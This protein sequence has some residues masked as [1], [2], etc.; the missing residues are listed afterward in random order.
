MK[1]KKNLRK[2]KRP[3]IPLRRKIAV[4]YS[5]IVISIK[6]LLFLVIYLFFFT[7]HLSFIKDE[8]AQNIYELTSDLGFKLE[9]VLI[10]GQYNISSQDILST[11]EA[12][13]GTPIFSINLN[14]VKSNL[15]KNSWVKTISIQ[16]RMPDTI[17]IDIVERVPIAIWLGAVRV[18]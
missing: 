5:K 6:I 13:K 9:N 15:E 16:R 12:D 2:T 14:E 7:K 11:L 10:E 3:N 18:D 8:I 4:I 17:Y 1:Q